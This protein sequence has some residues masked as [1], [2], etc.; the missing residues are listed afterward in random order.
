MSGVGEAAAASVVGTV[1]K[2]CLHTKWT[3]R[4]FRRLCACICKNGEDEAD[5]SYNYETRGTS[6]IFSFCGT[7]MT[8]SADNLHLNRNN[9]A[10]KSRHRQTTVTSEDTTRCGH[11]VREEC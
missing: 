9:T 4:F 5:G 2:R 1:V 3:D 11:G 8:E 7:V 10:Y 6:L